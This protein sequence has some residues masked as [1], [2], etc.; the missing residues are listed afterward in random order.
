[1]FR[2]SFGEERAFPF[3]HELGHCLHPSYVSVSHFH[4]LNVAEYISSGMASKAALSTLTAMSLDIADGVELMHSV[5]GGPYHHTDLRADQFMIDENG[6][7]MLNDFDRSKKEQYLFADNVSIRC[8]FCPHSAN[9]M[10]RA[11]E[12]EEDRSR[13]LDETTRCSLR[14]DG[15]LEP[16]F[17]RRT[18]CRHCHSP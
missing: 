10:G 5:R 17:R 8:P 14:G 12:F 11:P 4:A 3:V 16:L 18:R 13:N 7:V 9:G 15:H 2:S 6:N 1:M